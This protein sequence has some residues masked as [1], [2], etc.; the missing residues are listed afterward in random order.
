MSAGFNLLNY[1]IQAR[2]RRLRW[3]WGSA[4]VCGLIGLATGAGV[5]HGI[6]LDMRALALEQSQLQTQLVQRQAQAR[7]HKARQEA[8]VLAQRQQIFLTQVQQHQQAWLRLQQAVLQEAG[9]KGWALERL[10]VD[11]GR[12]ELQGRVRDAQSLAAAQTR[13]SEKLQTPLTLTSLVASPADMS[14]HSSTD[15]G[16]TDLGLVFVWHGDWPS[17]PVPSPRA[18]GSSVPQRLP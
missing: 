12:L 5:L 1:P 6:R 10:Q 18:S 4:L 9:R 16:P 3:R 8:Q 2:Q 11:G 7:A 14:D 13:L 17:L 15:H